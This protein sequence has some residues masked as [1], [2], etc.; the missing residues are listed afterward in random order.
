MNPVNR[1]CAAALVFALLAPAVRAQEAL[2][3]SWVLDASVSKTAVP[4]LAA[5]GGT[6]EIADAGAGKFASTSEITVGGVTGRSETTYAVDGKDYAITA[7]PAQPGVALTSSMERVSE[8]AFKSNV[9]MN[10]QLIATATTEISADQKTM[11]QT[12]TGL[13]QFAV[14]SSTVV[15]RRK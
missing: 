13:G 1:L 11:T 4:Q 5:A 10:G 12:T 3:G 14:L 15:F 9:K 6:L 8:T 2:V 7:T